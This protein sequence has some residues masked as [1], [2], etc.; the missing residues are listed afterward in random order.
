MVC[1]QK[2]VSVSS[3]RPEFPS[4]LALGR[5][6]GPGSIQL[7]EESCLQRGFLL[8]SQLRWGGLLRNPPLQQLR[9]AVLPAQASDSLDRKGFAWNLVAWEKALSVHGSHGSL[10]LRPFQILPGSDLWAEL[11]RLVS[12]GLDRPWGRGQTLSFSAQQTRPAGHFAPVP[13]FF[14]L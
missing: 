6:R 7:H 9:E 4:G 8:S 2:P 5:S 3:K 13:Q 12:S 1:C 11:A 14:L 10:L